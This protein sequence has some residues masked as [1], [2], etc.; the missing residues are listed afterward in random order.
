VRGSVE[1]HSS[2]VQTFVSELKGEEKLWKSAISESR[3]QDGGLPALEPEH[4]QIKAVYTERD[5]MRA[6]LTDVG[7]SECV[8]APPLSLAA[9]DERVRYKRL[10]QRLFGNSTRAPGARPPRVHLQDPTSALLP[11]G[12]GQSPS[13]KR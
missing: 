6:G 10:G 1:P 5:E 13:P 7:R 3:Q 4:R 12:L 8:N 11:R 9:G 2:S